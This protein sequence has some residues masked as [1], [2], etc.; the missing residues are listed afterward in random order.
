M[1]SSP[2]LSVGR[3][4]AINYALEELTSQKK[5]PSRSCFIVLDDDVLVS[6]KSLEEIESHFNNQ[7][8]IVFVSGYLR[9]Q[10]PKFIRQKKKKKHKLLNSKNFYGHTIE[11]AVSFR[12]SV[13]AESGVRYDERFGLGPDT[14]FKSG[15]GILFASGILSFQSPGLYCPDYQVEELYNG[16]EYS[17][18]TKRIWNYAVGE[19][20]ALSATLSSRW[21][22]HRI[23]LRP[24]V[25]ILF[26][27]IRIQWRNAFNK[28]I[29]L[30]GLIRGAIEYHKIR[31]KSS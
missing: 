10:N 11:S 8:E 20:A 1:I 18:S 28:S 29:R 19:G 14:V 25:G 27:L 31:R 5:D 13:I 7:N 24:V 23:L 30:M 21:L 26:T 22:L 6:K 9:N 12:A 17:E 2:G 3:N 15:E 16:G 4:A